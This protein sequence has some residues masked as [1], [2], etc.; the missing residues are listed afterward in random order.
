MRFVIG[1]RPEEMIGIG[2]IAAGRVGIGTWHKALH[3]TDGGWIEASHWYDIVG[4]QG[5]V[6]VSFYRT[7]CAIRTCVYDV[8][9]GLCADG[10]GGIKRRRG[11]IP[12]SLSG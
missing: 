8:G 3:N 4:E 2:Q 5:V 11:K 10:R 9:E 12:R 1:N 6:S 7:S